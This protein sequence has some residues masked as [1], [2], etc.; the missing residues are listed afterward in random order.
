MLQ[1]EFV[2]QT[3]YH[4]NTISTRHS[5]QSKSRTLLLTYRKWSYYFSREE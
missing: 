2:E 3:M 4:L 1:N 5:I